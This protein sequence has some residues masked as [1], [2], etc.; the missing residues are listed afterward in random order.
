MHLDTYPVITEKNSLV[1]DFVSEGRIDKIEKMIV[2]TPLSIP[3][4]FNLGFGD[5]NK[6]TGDFDDL[7]V[8][9]N[10]DSRKVLAT[11]ASTIYTFTEQYPNAIILAR[12]ATL[13][14]NRLYR[15]GIS[16]NYE[17]IKDDF[18]I[19]GFKNGNWH[20]FQRNLEFDQFLAKRKP[21]ERNIH[22]LVLMQK[23]YKGAII[24]GIDEEL[25]KY[26]YHPYFKKKADEA[27]EFIRRVGLPEEFK[28]KYPIPP[29]NPEKK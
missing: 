10:G 25:E 8:T 1:F 17:L 13:A 16:N 21:I 5:K 19:L 9:N 12:G 2:Y 18:K 7:V 14:R 3:G 22:N 20:P 4:Y 26:V 11:V 6:Y 29:L 24:I 28:D 15:M 27:E 23:N